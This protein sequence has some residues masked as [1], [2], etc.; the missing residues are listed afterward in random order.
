MASITA[1]RGSLFHLLDDPRKDSEAYE[2]IDDALLVIADGHIQAMGP[3]SQI[4]PTLAD[5]INIEEH[6]D[7]ILSP[8]FFDLH[9]HFPQLTTTAVYGEQLLGWLNTSSRKKRSTKTKAMPLNALSY[10]SGNF[11][12]TAPQR[13]LC[14]GPGPKSRLMPSSKKPLS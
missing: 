4:K 8:G 13:Q 7:A 2:F 9:I 1:H 12:A 3:Y 14:M 11:S 5:N 6:P 10:F